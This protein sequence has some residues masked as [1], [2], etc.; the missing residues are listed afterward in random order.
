MLSIIHQGWGTSNLG[1][2]LRILGVASKVG[3]KDVALKVSKKA[4]SHLIPFERPWVGWIYRCVA[5]GEWVSE[6]VCE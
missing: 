2:T 3:E 6:S 4:A 1:V 5:I